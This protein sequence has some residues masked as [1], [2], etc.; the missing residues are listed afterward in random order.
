MLVLLIIATI[1]WAS[2]NHS[3][4]TTASSKSR[5]LS[6]PENFNLTYTVESYNMAGQLYYESAFRLSSDGSAHEFETHPGAGG[7][8]P[9]INA[10]AM[11]SQEYVD[12]LRDAMNKDGLCSLNGT[13]NDA[14]WHQMGSEKEIENLTIQT[15]CGNRTLRFYGDAVV[16]VI[17]YTYVAINRIAWH[18]SDPGIDILSISMDVSARLEANSVVNI[19]AILRNNAPHVVNMAGCSPDTWRAEIVRSNGCGVARIDYDVGTLCVWTVEPGGSFEFNPH[20][21]AADGLAV[22]R[23]VVMASPFAWGV[24]VF[25][26][27]Q[28]LGHTNQ[29]PHISVQILKSTDSEDNTYVLDASESCDE[30]DLPKDLQVR[31][32]WYSD[33]T[34]DTD[35]SSD[36]TAEFTFAD[37]KEYNLTIEVRDS[38][39]FVSSTSYGMTTNHSVWSAPL[40]VAL[41][42]IVAAAV[43]VALLL[44]LRRKE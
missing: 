37:M 6:V 18:V 38:D 43:A 15:P 28:D 26:I 19:S 21:W 35:W 20:M 22:G 16:G 29:A 31:W 4:S 7:L 33:G 32:D 41:L 42:V 9:D 44:F 3:A 5:S 11:L 14:G 40:T 39:G 2:G 10:S 12:Y 30:E 24:T 1:L 34:W 23:Y 8:P 36:K 25:N 13:Y 17:P 27:T